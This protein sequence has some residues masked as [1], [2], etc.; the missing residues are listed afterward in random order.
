MKYI[1]SKL[2]WFRNNIMNKWWSFFL[3]LIPL[4]AVISELFGNTGL[5]ILCLV[6]IYI[7]FYLEER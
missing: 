5:V 3:I 7:A 6:E 1:N 2:T 4:L